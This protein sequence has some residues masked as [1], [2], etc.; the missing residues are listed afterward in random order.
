MTIDEPRRDARAVLRNRNF[1]FFLVVT[2]L[3]S[4]SAQ[5]ITITVGWELYDRTGSAFYLGLIGLVELVP[6]VLLALPAGQIVDRHDRKLVAFGAFAVIALAS[7]LLSI[8][9]FTAAPLIL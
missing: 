1:Q 8:V 4:V 5:M 7:F 6:V 3:S 2:F 9:S